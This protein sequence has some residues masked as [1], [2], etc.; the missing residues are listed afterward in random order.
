MQ[1]SDLSESEEKPVIG[2]ELQGTLGKPSVLEWSTS[3]K[4]GGERECVAVTR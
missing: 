2:K 1:L 4:K 3:R